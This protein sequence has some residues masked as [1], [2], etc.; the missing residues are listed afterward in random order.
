MAESK[1]QSLWTCFFTRS[2]NIWTSLSFG[3]PDL[4]LLEK[5]NFQKSQ[6]SSTLLTL[7]G[8]WSSCLPWI[9]LQWNQPD[10]ILLDLNLP[11]VQAQLGIN[12]LDLSSL[13]TLI[14]C[15]YWSWFWVFES[16]WPIFWLF[17][18]INKIILSTFILLVP[19][20]G[21]LNLIH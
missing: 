7:E 13:A 9:H 6:L 15:C 5:A 21:A 20:K 16:C 18:D 4:G 11:V 19:N 8:T 2:M 14:V 17:L 1:K 3:P 12:T 10:G